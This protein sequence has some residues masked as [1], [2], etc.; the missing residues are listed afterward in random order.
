MVA[1]PI[2]DL[3]SFVVDQI[4]QGG[5]P[6]NQKVKLLR[7]CALCIA[8]EDRANE[9][10]AAAELIESASNAEKQLLLNFRKKR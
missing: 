9:F 3:V 2:E 5:I 1:N 10:L 8:Q 4:D 7:A 6:A